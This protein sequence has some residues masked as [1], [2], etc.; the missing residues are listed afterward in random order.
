MLNDRDLVR[1]LNPRSLSLGLLVGLANGCALHTAT[2]ATRRPRNYASHFSAR[3]AA[4]GVAPSAPRRRGRAG[5]LAQP[6][7][8]LVD[9]GVG[10]V[11]AAA[12][13]ERGLGRGIPHEMVV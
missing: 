4:A 13:A 8:H 3:G 6:A 2:A 10:V 5:A 9:G 7:Q 12:G 11:L 1:L